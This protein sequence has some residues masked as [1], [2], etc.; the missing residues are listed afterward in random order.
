V[1]VANQSLGTIRN[2]ALLRYI[3]QARPKGDRWQ[4]IFTRW[5]NGLVN[6]VRGLGG[7]PNQVP[8]SLT[9]PGTAVITIPHEKCV[10]G[11]VARVR[12][13]CF[14]DFE[15]FDLQDCDERH[16]FVSRERG[17]DAIVLRACCERTRLEVRF[18]R[19]RRI[20]GIVIVCGE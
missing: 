12:Y 9:D 5:I 10:T 6:K 3:A 14:G 15:G 16:H 2:L 17:I 13:D 18:S 8:P 11:K 1:R 20:L 7:D 19:S 4:P